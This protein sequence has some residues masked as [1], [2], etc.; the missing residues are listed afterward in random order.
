MIKIIARI[1]LSSLILFSYTALSS[2]KLAHKILLET[3]AANYKD[4]NNNTDYV[5]HTNSLFISGDNYDGGYTLG[6]SSANTIEKNQDYDSSQVK[7]FLSTHFH[8]KLTNFKGSFTERIDAYYL[9]T[10]K[11]QSV[12]NIKILSPQ[13][14]WL[15]DDSKKLINMGYTYSYYSDQQSVHQFTPTLGASLTDKDWLQLRAYLAQ[16]SYSEKDKKEDDRAA[17][18]IK[19]T[20]NFKKSNPQSKLDYLQFSTVLGNR[21]Y[22]VDPDTATVYDS[23]GVQTKAFT[24][25][26]KWDISP[27]N[28]IGLSAGKATY[29]AFDQPY[30]SNFISANWTYEPNSAKASRLLR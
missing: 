23:G 14:T 27:S 22:T 13:I 17:L 10:D 19:L 5:S 7:L 29:E 26:S 18:E 30:N 1:S 3:I 24:I 20:H 9:N 6:Y 11:T 15:S 21:E 8:N 25:N 4:A 2:E 28:S 16:T 12:D